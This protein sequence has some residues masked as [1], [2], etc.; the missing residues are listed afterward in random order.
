MKKYLLIITDE[1]QRHLAYRANITA[2][3]IGHIIDVSAQVIIWSVIFSQVSIIKGY[4]LTEMMTYVV[5]GWFFQHASSNYNFE[6]RVARDIERGTLSS[7]LIKPISYLRYITACAIGRVGFAFATVWGIAVILLLLMHDRLIFNFNP[8]ILLII[9]IMVVIGFFI[10]LL[11][12][13]IIGLFAIWVV[14]ISGTYFSLNIIAKFLSGAMFPIALLPS[15]FIN[16]TLLFPFAYTLF[17]PLQLY[18]GK[19]SIYQGVIGV[20]VEL[21]WLIILYGI[22]KLIWHF[23]LKKYESVGI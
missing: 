1:F 12:S 19:I 10:K 6:E 23:G 16:L 22:V 11:F 4:T 2:Y 21:V 17:V 13:L 7:L 20:G 3:S 14:E 5:F 18:L 8:I 9:L 15:F